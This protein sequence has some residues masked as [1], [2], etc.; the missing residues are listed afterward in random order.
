MIEG[1]R[2]DAIITR[3]RQT[4]C[5]SPPQMS[6]RTGGTKRLE[7]KFEG[8]NGVL[9]N[10]KL[11]SKKL[12]RLF[13]LLKGN[14]KNG[15]VDD[16]ELEGLSHQLGDAWEALARRL[17]F[18]EAEIQGLNY[19][20]PSY[21]KKQFNMLYEWK[22]RLGS[23]ATYKVLFDA[24]C[25]KYVKRERL[26]ETWCIWNNDAAETSACFNSSSRVGINFSWFVWFI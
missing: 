19:N 3:Q 8:Q 9:V 7:K 23:G 15:V 5:D 4:E 1:I 24:L 14:I 25:H 18:N 6:V 22:Q 16:E 17:G 13:F 20:Y 10:R 2:C 21:P 11:L 26:A 12:N